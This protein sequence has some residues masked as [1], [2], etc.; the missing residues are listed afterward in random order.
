ME[1]T[2][3]INKTELA[4]ISFIK[5]TILSGK[6]QAE[7]ATLLKSAIM[8]AKDGSGK[9][10]IT[11]ESKNRGKFEVLAAILTAGQEFLILKGGQTIPI[12]SIIKISL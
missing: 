2:I 3:K 4:K 7:R 11:F 10:N 9:V 1:K 5:E 6:E 12:S 8:K